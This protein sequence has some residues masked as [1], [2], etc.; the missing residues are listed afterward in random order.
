MNSLKALGIFALAFS[1]VQCNNTEEKSEADVLNDFA[2]ADSTNQVEVVSEDI[3][4]EMIYSIP[5]PVEMTTIILESGAEF[6]DQLVNNPDQVDK[7]DTPYLKALNLGIYGA[8]LGYL[9]MYK[10]T[11][12]SINHLTTVRSLAKDLKIEQFFDFNT[13]KRLA[14][15]NSNI[16]SLVNITTQSFLEMEGYL[17]ENNRTKASVLIVTGTFVEGL[18]ISGT[19]ANETQSPEL[20]ERLAEQKYAVE[21][22]MVMLDVYKNDPEMEHIHAL[23][24][25]LNTAYAQVEIVVTEGEVVEKEVDGMLVF[26]NTST[27]TVNMTDEVFASILKTIDSVRSQII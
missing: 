17:R 10:K 25:E 9:N 18:H 8:D 20:K 24:S 7:Y 26:E 21:N 4:A 2:Y 11:M 6:N 12:T 22:L 16:D 13:L 14:T 15:S 19:I 23:I 5:S 27:S 3:I 1:L